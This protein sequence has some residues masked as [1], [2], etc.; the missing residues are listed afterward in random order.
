MSQEHIDWLREDFKVFNGTGE[1]NVARLAPDFEMHQAASVIDTAGVF[2]GRD[3]LQQSLGELQGAFVGLRFEAEKFFEAP[4][5]EIVVFIRVRGRGVG[6][7]VEIDN[8]I[9]WVWTF[10]GEEAI[11]LVVYEQQTEALEAVGLRE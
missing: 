7:G 4:A 10:R 11:R 2:R 1:I 9:A 6:S 5:D 8:R 3:A